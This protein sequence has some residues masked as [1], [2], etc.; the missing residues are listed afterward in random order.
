VGARMELESRARTG[1]PKA[2]WPRPWLWL[3][4]LWCPEPFHGLW[5]LTQGLV[6][7]VHID[8]QMHFLCSFFFG[9]TRV[10][11]QGFTLTKQALHHLSHTSSPF[12]SGDFEDGG[13]SDYL[14][15]LSL[16]WGPPDL[17]LPS[18]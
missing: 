9:S 3:L 8:S 6:R 14:T 15:R 4:C 5:G 11:T 7:P 18:S 1:S 12:C 13:C 17:S 16:N 10:W 2:L